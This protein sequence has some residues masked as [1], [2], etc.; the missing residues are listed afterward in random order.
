MQI[1][2][3]VI[4]LSFALLALHGWYLLRDYQHLKRHW[5]EL[6]GALLERQK[7]L[8]EMSAQLPDLDQAIDTD[9]KLLLQRA[10]DIH[11]K[12]WLQRAALETRLSLKTGQALSQIDLNADSIRLLDHLDNAILLAL[13]LYQISANRY[14]DRR[15]AF[16]GSLLGTLAG[17]SVAPDIEIESIKPANF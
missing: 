15:E 9:L 5:Q 2:L 6:D 17:L 11:P 1:W 14:N 7:A 4:I 10:S 13:A 16:P 12:R 8:L 3:I